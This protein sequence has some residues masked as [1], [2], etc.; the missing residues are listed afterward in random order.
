[1]I[2][3]VTVVYIAKFLS[4]SM[5]TD[6]IVLLTAVAYFD[7]WPEAKAQHKPNGKEQTTFGLGSHFTISFSLP[8]H[9]MYIH[10]P[11]NDDGQNMTRHYNRLDTMQVA[12]ALS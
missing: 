12:I 3:V 4:L 1:M 7:A 6:G 11:M 5:V 2:V 9:C 10:D 8:D